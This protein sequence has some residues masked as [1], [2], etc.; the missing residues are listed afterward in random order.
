[1]DTESLVSAGFLD[2]ETVPGDLHGATARLRLTV[3]P[4]DEMV[5]PCTV[6]DPELARSRPRPGTRRHRVTGYLRIPRHTGRTVVARCR[7]ARHA[8]DRDDVVRPGHRHNGRYLYVVLRHAAS[9]R[10]TLT[11]TVAAA[12]ALTA[13]TIR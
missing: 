6:I 3:S 10:E 11:D 5:L 7:H 8:G 1:M 12:L 9:V 4:T 2:E 13:A